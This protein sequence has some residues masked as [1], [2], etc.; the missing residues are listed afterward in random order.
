MKD[1]ERQVENLRLDNEVQAEKT[2]LAEKKALEKR[3]K[4]TEGKDW[5]K[6][7]GVVRGIH[8]NRE[9][10]HDLYGVSPE[11]K[12]YTKPNSLRKL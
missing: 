3:M 4:K 10:L 2:A 9:A 8:P 12:E 1:K 6:L 11:L 5:K 7:L